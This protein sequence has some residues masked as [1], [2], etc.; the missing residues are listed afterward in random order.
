LRKEKLPS[1]TTPDWSV[2]QDNN[3]GDAIVAAQALHAAT[4]FM[5]HAW[6]IPVVK[7]PGWRAIG[8]FAERSLPGLVI[9]NKKGERFGN[10]ADPYLESG[11]ALY[12]ADSIPS[13][14]VFDARFR[15]KYPFGPL[16]PGWATPDKFINKK[17]KSIWARAESVPALAEK[18]GV[19]A[20]GLQKTIERNNTF[21]QTGIDEDCGRGKSYYDRYY[22]DHHNKPNPCIAKISEAPFYALPLHPG[23]IGTKGGLVTNEHAQVLN[24][25]GDAIG[26]LYACGNTSSAVMGDKYLGAGATLGPAMT[27]GYL[28]GKHITGSA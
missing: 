4:S 28:A 20:A 22:G 10:E 24:E 5:E 19:D 25:T 16:G 6:W 2:S 9:V 12:A 11:Y 15:K 18:L 13:W 1:P 21:A 8:I 3:T 23:D 26:G 27:F 14:V 7:V 17:V